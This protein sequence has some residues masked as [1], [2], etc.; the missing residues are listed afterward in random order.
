MLQYLGFLFDISEKIIT[1]KLIAECKKSCSQNRK[2]RVE[3]EKISSE[4]MISKVVRLVE[5]K[6]EEIEKVK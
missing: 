4:E 5:E 1:N 2:R 3:S 6:V